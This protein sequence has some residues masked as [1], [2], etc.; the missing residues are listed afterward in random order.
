MAQVDERFRNPIS[1]AELDRRWASVREKMR[2]AKID[3][4]VIQGANNFAGLGGYFRWF[5]GIPPLGTYPQSVI[6]PASGPM[7]IVHHGDFGGEASLDPINGPHYGIARRLTTPMFPAVRYCADYDADLIAKEI[8][9]SGYKTIS[10]VG[11]SMMYH[12]FASRLLHQLGGMQYAEFT[13]TLDV[14]KAVKSAEDIGWIRKAAAMQDEI[15]AKVLAHVKPGMHDYEVMAYSDYVG[16][17]L[18]G[19]TG[20]FLGSSSPPGKPALFRM[21]PHHGRRMDA[22]DVLVWQA[23][24][25]G[26]GG[27]FA[28]MCR[29]IVLGKAPQELT[30]MIGQ[31]IEMQKYTLGLLK[32]GA[33]CSDIFADYN[34]AMKKRGY[35]EEKRLH[36][37]GQGYENVERPL[38]RSDETMSI[39]ANMNIGI[40]PIIANERVAA[41][42]S[43]N[44][45]TTAA[46]QPERLHQTPQKVFEL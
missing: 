39:A 6:F 38:I 41:T 13:E 28:H 25:S 14:I 27:Y 46:G 24:N 23:E 15:F 26:P 32:P 5:T 12:G 21:K 8:K 42:I 4:L 35:Q 19:E 34:A 37:H 31:T 9:G 17:V 1:T 36:C 10:L 29:Y 16:Q 45:L 43:D 22:G 20:Y 3:A 18:D 11:S 30:D 40:H 33:K 2:E 44:F 7:T